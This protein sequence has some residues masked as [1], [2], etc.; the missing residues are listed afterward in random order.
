VVPEQRW[1]I[2]EA[3]DQAPPRTLVGLKNGW[4]EDGD[5]WQLNSAG[6]VQPGDGRPVYTIAI[7]TRLQPSLPTG[8]ATIEGVARLIHAALLGRVP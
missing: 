7:L 6:F 5:G 3:L 1:G 8:L 2:A 4:W